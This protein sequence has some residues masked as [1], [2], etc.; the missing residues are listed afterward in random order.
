MLRG[1]FMALIMSVKGKNTTS[2]LSERNNKISHMK[3]RADNKDKSRNRRVRKLKNSKM[4][5]FESFKFFPV[6]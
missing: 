5:K 2:E 3:A 1:E 6:R 4:H